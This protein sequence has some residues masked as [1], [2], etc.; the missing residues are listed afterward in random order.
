MNKE[1]TLEE[2]RTIQLDILK[3]IHTFCQKH[4]LRY[5]LGGGTLLGAVRHKGYI[6]WDDDVDIMM[7]RPDYEKF[8]KEFENDASKNLTVQCYKNDETYAFL[9]AKV[10]D[11]RTTLIENGAANGIY[12]DI[13]PID[14]L[15]SKKELAK[16]LQTLNEM[17]KNVVKTTKYYNFQNKKSLKLRYWIKCLLYPNRAKAI[18]LLESF[19]TSYPFETSKFAGAITGRY[20]EKEWMPVSTFKNY[21][22][23]SFE[24]DTF[25]CI[26]DYDSYLEKHYGDYM[27]LP[28]KEQQVSNH[29]FIAYWK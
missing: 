7:P 6:P 24:G 4:S 12:V 17:G 21:I 28:P 20:K 14:G 16:Y 26:A 9:F 23:L 2:M 1:I 8:L 27:Q 25:S 22:S 13:F 18:K 11:N 10:F 5:S 29:S 19:F 15:P 3:Q